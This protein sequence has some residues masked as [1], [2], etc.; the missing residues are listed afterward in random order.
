MIRHPSYPVEEWFVR[1]TAFS[2]EVLTESESLFALA[3]G[4]LGVRGT[5]DEGAPA[6]QIGTYIAGVHEERPLTYPERFPAFPTTEE[7][8]VQVTDATGMRLEV[9]SYP[10]DVRTGV[11][12]R[13]ERILDL[14]SGTL[15]R[16]V[17]W[18][19]PSGARVQVNSY[20]IVSLA[21]PHL[22]AIRYR[23]EALDE[24]RIVVR[25][26]LDG[27]E[28]IHPASTDPRESAPL[29][30]QVLLP[31]HAEAD[32]QFLLLVHSTHATR[33]MVACGA[34]HTALVT[35]QDGSA[36]VVAHCTPNHAE[37]AFSI[38]AGPSAALTIDKMVAYHSSTT[39]GPA[40]LARRVRRSLDVAATSGF[41]ALAASQREVL[42]A[43]WAYADIE[44]AGD[45]ELEQGL[46]FAMFNILQA[47]AQAKGHPVPAKGL[48]GQG[49]SGHTFWDTEAFVVPVLTYVRPDLARDVLQFRVATLDAAR[50][51]ASELGHAGACFPW[52]TI[53]GR[54]CSG[55]FPSG[56][57]GYHVNADIA[58]AICRYASATGD[59]D[60]LRGQA[61]QVLVETARLWARLGHFDPRRGGRFCIDRVTGPDEYSA[62]V[63]NNIYT[64]LAAQ[65]NLRVA[66]RLVEMLPE[67]DPAAHA[68]LVAS[69]GVTAQEA[70]HWRHVAE[71][72]AIPYDDGLGIHPQDDSFLELA[73]WD[74]SS[75]PPDDRPLLLHYHPMTLYRH[76]IVKQADIVLALHLF[77]DSFT[78]EEKL[79]DF[80]YYEPITVHD[81]SLSPATHAV[82]A[83]ELGDLDKARSYARRSALMDINN[84]H[85]DV[86][87]GIHIAACAGGW[88]SVVMGFGGLRD[89]GDDGAPKLS[90]RLPPGWDRL[91][92]QLAI[93]GERV[94]VDITSSSTTYSIH[95][96]PAREAGKTLGPETS[97]P[98]PVRVSL[99][100]HGALITLAPGDSRTVPTTAG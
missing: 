34:G 20:R 66:A 41:D 70:G 55:Y 13:H 15:E 1:E 86:R 89:P 93:R 23:V 80:A 57:A 28:S 16:R 50:S 91:K 85:Q 64:N 29:Y 36:E 3:N 95:A 87:S 68:A 48:T 37:T 6:G 42:D 75:E 62:L 24:A 81:S 46:R 54:E 4:A 69:T 33:I 88:I 10:L 51:R 12:E 79:R 61:S 40:E 31:E 71:A 53:T 94:V 84:I 21:E 90:P 67:A 58:L 100:H 52:R 60:F 25:S 83:A 44:I 92:F 9:D 8:L 47:T 73:P 97:E 59:D 45:P 27:N 78:P 22:L 77:A 30:G 38:A 82:V 99:W 98:Q 32:D 74:F 65:A 19:A 49:Y 26:R 11:L 96:A 5:L 2:P 18:Q 39:E 7:T 35:G 17:I 56:S 43:Y 72:M 76:Q 63:N 14:R